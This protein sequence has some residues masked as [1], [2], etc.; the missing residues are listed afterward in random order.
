MTS[1]SNPNLILIHECLSSSEYAVY[2]K[3]LEV[4]K[5][6]F[7]DLS[8]IEGKT[9]EEKKVAEDAWGRKLTNK[10]KDWSGPFSENLVREFLQISGKIARKPKTIVGRKKYNLDLET[11]DFIY[12]IK[13]Q[14]YYTTGTAGEK[15][16][17][18]QF[19][20]AEVPQLVN[21]PLIIIVAACAEK[22]SEEYGIFPEN[23]CPEQQ[24]IIKMYESMNNRFERFTHM[25]EKY[26]NERWCLTQN[27]N[28]LTS[29][30]LMG[31]EQELPLLSIP[32][33]LNLSADD[34]QQV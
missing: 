8:F 16:M 21:K 13:S 30:S 27:S 33:S 7:G 32:D 12:E 14:T 10:L 11:D 3:H 19:K 23:S 26:V 9:M 22:R 20:Y 29:S 24:K 25:I 31:C 34:I 18:S 1:T 2:F 28:I 5:W 6:L 15:I 4:I 17:G